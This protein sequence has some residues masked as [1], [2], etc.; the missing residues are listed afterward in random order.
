V[1]N[2][3]RDVTP[4]RLLALYRAVREFGSYPLR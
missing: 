3:Q 4:E 1:H 2:I